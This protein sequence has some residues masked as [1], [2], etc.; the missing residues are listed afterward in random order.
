MPSDADE[1]NILEDKLESVERDAIIN[2]L[3]KCKYNKTAA[4][5]ELGLTLRALRYRIAKLN[6]N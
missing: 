2:A 3:I 4:A 6:I 5:K 1:D